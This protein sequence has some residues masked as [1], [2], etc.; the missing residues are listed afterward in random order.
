MKQRRRVAHP[1]ESPLGVFDGD[2]GFCRLWLARWKAA[3]GRKVDYAPS[4]EVA[5]RF[6]EIPPDAFKR[7]FQL[8]LPDGE[9]LEGAEA[10]LATLAKAPGGK[11]VLYALYRNVPGLAPL[12]DLA[13][14]TIARHRSAA[15]RVTRLLWGS[16][17]VKPT[18]AAA[19]S[20]FL[21][22]LG[23]CYLAA[24]LSLWV[25]VD[26]LVGSG[27][28][29]PVSRFL[30]WVRS[31]TG[32]ERYWLAPTLSWLFPS[33]AGLHVL[34]GL[35][36]AASLALLLGLAPAV[37]AAAAWVLSLSLS[38]S[39]QVFLEYQWDILL[40]EAGLLAIF[41]AA[42]RRLRLR[43]GLAVPPLARFLLVWLLFRV[44]FSSGLVKLTSGDPAWRD[45]TALQYHYW[46]QP[47]P[48]WVGWFV[49]LAPLSFHKLSC[50]FLF[51]VELAVPLLFFAPRRLR[52]LAFAMTVLLEVLIAVTGNYAFFNLLTV[53]LAVLLLDDEVVPRRWREGAEREAAARPGRWPNAILVPAA[54]VLLAVSAVP[55]AATLGIAESIP[56]PLISL[57]SLAAPF[58]SANGYGLF[59]V[60]TKTRPEI[61]VEG[62]DDGVTWRAYEFRWKPGDPRR[63]PAFVA[64]HQPR[65]DW[66]MW[67]AALGS[68]E[69]SP[70]FAAFL[71][72]L[73]E[74]SP[75]V[76]GLLASNP[77]S[78][79][80]PRFV[81]AVLYD[82]RFTDAQTRRQTGAWWRRELRGPYSPPLSL[83][84]W[85][86]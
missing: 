41:L 26:G 66:Q 20:L 38:V 32:A 37:A 76:E 53:A 65:L 8:V 57:Y 60:M 72:R 83:A 75:D 1:P 80:P 70:W 46:T 59:A 15:L 68:F 63:R 50:A 11:G 35:G 36:V 42:P 19:G 62:S 47:L 77:F 29:L 58:R 40:T 78:N 24:F 67:F 81:R 74:G 73:L 52:V 86:R 9:V 84:S 48:T 61:L 21:R 23:L 43:R 54:A 79:R 17:V 55:F 44:M 4:Q 27:G 51:F 13:Y 7:A 64:P 71:R 28:I 69:E 33:D 10:V 25:Q 49:N 31:H 34:C 22:L 30:D 39:G 2:C 85:S 56:R 16:S 45:L 82:Y 14:R 12:L 6:P 5:E 3:R 18:Y